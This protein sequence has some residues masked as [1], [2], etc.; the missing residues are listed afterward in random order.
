[1]TTR[2]ATKPTDIST[3]DL[4]A[5]LTGDTQGAISRLQ[6]GP[7]DVVSQIEE[8]DR[9]LEEA[10][11]IQ[12]ASKRDAR[13]KVLN[14]NFDNI[15]QGMMKEEQDLGQ[16]VFGLQGILTAMGKEYENLQKPSAS[17]LSIITN[18]EATL[19]AAE[20]DL[21]TAKASWNFFGS[22]DRAV[23]NAETRIQ[24]A[25]NSIE[26]AKIRVKQLARERLMSADIE[27]SL[28]TFMK[29]VSETVDI[30]QKRMKAI[31]EQV[32]QVGTRKA[33]A[34]DIKQ[35]A[36]E[37]LEKLDADLKQVEAN[38]Q[39][40]EEVLSTFINGSPEHSEQS[41]K[42][43]NLRA[44][45]ENLRGRRNAALVLFQSKERFAGELEVHEKAQIKL[46]DNQRAWI[47]LL[48]SDTEER[49]VTFK[50][51]L[52]A[53][54]AMSD[55]DIAQQL[56]QVGASVDQ[57]NIEFMASV[58]TASDKRAIEMIE[59]Q[60]GRVRMINQVKAAQ[61]E[62]TALIRDRYAEQLRQ[63]RETYGINPLD[64]SFFSYGEGSGKSAETHGSGV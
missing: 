35:K 24:E 42:I 4:L 18:A 9:Q 60:P 23:A 27:T 51:R 21:A 57:S 40:E 10:T 1:M 14:A 45:V 48:K 29:M 49:I 12:D 34:F 11:T 13:M 33:K 52:E 2:S 59:E 15:R 30:M 16:A 43:S 56:N 38:L 28:Q 41:A 61:A 22:R 50:S 19:K 7:A 31:E 5:Q 64:D 39:G 53:M 55:Q 46:R 63:F 44:D 32:V 25:Q 58:G 47:T 8:L 54:K 3:D 36:A 20:E 37:A 26:E 17:E 6:D 62:A